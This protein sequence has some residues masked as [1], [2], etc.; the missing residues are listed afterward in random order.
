[1]KTR[2]SLFCI[3]ITML[4]SFSIANAQQFGQLGGGGIG[5]QQ[6]AFRAVSGDLLQPGLPG[7]LWFET[8][9]AD[10]GLGFEGSYLTLGGKTRLF[11]DF[12]DGR[13]LL[14]GQFNHSID[15]DGG[16]FLNIGIE[17]VFSIA[18]ANADISVGVFYD[19]DEDDQ[20]TFSDGFH[21]IGISGA[22][23]T[24]RFDLIG[25]GYLPVGTDNFTLGDLSGGNAFVGNN[26]ALQ[27]GI[28]SA[29]Q[30]FDV[31]L[32]TRPHQLA[33]GNGFVDF[34][35]YHYDSDIVDPFA[36]GRL[37][38]GIQLIN[39]IQLAAEVNHDERFDT[40]GALSLVFNFGG[41]RN[42]RGSEYAGL[43]RDLEQFA[44]NDH[45]VRFSQDLIVATNP[46]TGQAFN[47]IHANNTQLGIGDGT[48]ES[49]FATL[50]EAEAA[51]SVDDVIFV[52]VGDGTD[53]GYQ[54]GIALQDRQQLLS[55][56]GTQF[57]QN[58]D[59]TL[60]AVT[61]PGSV[62][63]TISNVG[64]NEVVSLADG[65]VVA[66]VNIDATGAT[67]GVFGSGVN[68]GTISDSTI[69]GAT[70][71]GVG[72]QNVAGNFSFTNNTISDNM[73]DGVF[74]DGSTDPTAVFNFTNNVVDMN[75]FEGIHLADF[76]ASNV[77]LNGNQTSNNGRNGVKID[78]A[79]NSLGAGTDILLTNH[80][81][82]SNGANGVTIEEGSGSVT[83]A[84]GA[85]TNNAAAGLS[86]TNWQATG[87]D[88]ITI[89][90]LPDGTQPDFS[91]NSVGINLSLAGAGL[92]QTVTIDDATINN[93]DR[94]IV[95][96]ADGVDTV[97]NLNVG[98]TTTINNSANQAIDH[99]AQG[100]ATINSVIAGD[101][102]ANPLVINN[103]AT[104]GGIASAINFTLDGTDPDN[105]TRINA[106][107]RDVNV[108]NASGG[109]ALNI[110][111][112]GESV[113]DLLV[114]DS[115]L[116][117][118]G[119]AVQVNLNNT[120]N[121]EL[122]RTFFDNV[123][124]FGTTGFV[125]NSQPGTL[126]DISITNSLFDGDG[127][128]VLGG[129]PLFS[130]ANGLV[131]TTTGGVIPGT[132]D[133]DNFT[134]L[135]FASNTVQDFIFDGVQIMT[136]GDAQLFT[137]ITSNQITNNGPG[138]DNDGM[139]DDGVLDGPTMAFD[140]ATG[141]FFD[142][143]DITAAGTSTISLAASNNTF[144]NNFQR[145]LDLATVGGGQILATATGNSFASDI[146]AD[147]TMV[148]LDLFTG[149]VGVLNTGGQISLSLSSNTF[150]SMPT[151]DVNNMGAPGNVTIGL[152]GLSNGFNAAGL[153]GVF[154]PSAFGL[155]DALI[156]AEANTFEANGFEDV[157]H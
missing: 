32:R 22:I 50:A 124:F 120:I 36:G 149:Q 142:G 133:S 78:N 110:N 101:D 40:T 106:V 93:N 131:L 58:A 67:F 115:T 41:Y 17:R 12:L 65:N 66:G 95:A 8:N 39:G 119:T 11:Q 135:N 79:L 33:F 73:Q 10:Q 14:E 140:P 122:N 147:G 20:Q 154:T 61:A 148:S 136:F 127:N 125:G 82:D 49:P 129:P 29:L 76:E 62:A 153:P 4:L 108:V 134:R 56:G 87:D 71:D 60:V 55:G 15:D 144:L 121:G 74:V 151:V 75:V 143:I 89:G 84:G 70:L 91:N 13:W 105:R 132:M 94:G 117:S 141:F 152:D 25:N 45:I 64:G 146:G 3:A 35:V 130:G 68:G 97:L 100:G 109:Q 98:G 72:L 28:E 104:N 5:G 30:G 92:T 81:A 145:S 38:A 118:A 112:T 27:S 138:Q 44:R 113:I 23:K 43:A 51:S 86:L 18:P 52:N 116:Q 37:R 85:F 19:Y 88:A 83:V 90:T 2:L 26:I 99:I 157:D 7:R 139:T 1:M 31:T 96:S 21:Q 107:V 69:M 24:P 9:F 114:E 156:D 48:V 57:V 150:A 123:N 80:V 47:V 126:W 102:A 16:L 137:T 103:N 54:N 6:S 42:G 77:I 34:G 155:T 59:G 63:A 111:G 128:P 53:T 46:L